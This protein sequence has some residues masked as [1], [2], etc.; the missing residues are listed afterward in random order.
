MNARL[1]WLI[2][3]SLLALFLF[4]S[5]LPAQRASAPAPSGSDWAEWRGPNRDGVSLEKGFP[6]KWSSSLLWKE[7]YGGRSTPIVMGNRVFVFNSSGKDETMQ[8]RLMCLDA[9]TGKPIWEYKINVYSTDVP[10]RRIAWSSPAGDPTTGNVYVFGATGALVAVSNDGKLLWERSLTDEFGAWTTHGGRTVSP[11]IEGDLVIVSMPTDG[12]GDLAQRRHR[13]YA[14]DKKTGECVWISTPGGRPY[15][16]TYSTPIV[17]TI[18]G[19]RLMI[20]GGGDGAVHAL[21]VNTGEPVWKYEFSKRGVNQGIV[22]KG[23]TAFISHPDE[24]I[25]TNEQGLLAAVDATAKGTIGKDQIKW[26]YRGYQLGPSS[27]VIDGDRYYQVDGGANLFA[28]DANT[29]KEL[30]KQNLGTIQ[31][32]SLVLADG[33]LYVGT[34]NGKFFIIKP[35]PTG[36]Q[37][38]DSIQL[39]PEIKT[40]EA[41]DLGEDLIASNEQ[42]IASVAASRGRI[43][44]VTTKNVYCLGK[45]T[46]SPALPA[47]KVVI[48]NAPA[49]AAVAHVQVVPA[50]L[51]ARPGESAKFR[52]RLFDDHGRFIREE[53]NA[54]WSLDGLKG[55]AQNNQFTPSEAGA[56]M[57]KATVGSVTGVSRVRVIPPLPIS[58]DF[59][60]I[61]PGK[62]PA[63]WLNADGKYVVREMDGGKVLVKNPNP[64]IFRRSRSPI[65]PATLS[66]YTVEADVR[67]T[68]KR[69]Q[70]GDAGVVAQRYELVLSGNNQ[71]LEL[72][73]WQIEPT[74]TARIPFKWKAD[75]WYHLKLRVENM[76]DGK[77]RARGKVWLASETEPEAW[78]IERVDPIGNRQ[79][80]PGIY[81]DAP[82]EVFFDNIRITPN[83]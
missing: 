26:L 45:K 71:R 28:F 66:D 33:K 51:I 17:A 40:T 31:K 38:L 27:P 53:T 63:Y 18:N 7:P 22:L 75:T 32:A 78:M 9:D 59:E 44:L 72:Q 23:T 65:G 11:I 82:F 36:C 49:D 16:T 79:G 47:H 80:S 29:G 81:A 25:D 43:Y 12:F 55:T 39:E 34:E 58:E 57:V 76:P 41:S 73:S 14:F 21:K 1:P 48:E 6:E 60:K 24:I 52:V 50:D 35:G 3:L 8:E 77:V 15:D 5:R 4:P 2:T 37:I 62:V 20:S 83:R 68:E 30:W 74:R 13:F 10:P 46:K 69:R 67:A 70:I 42:I 56:G 54:T 19:T 64:P 61:A